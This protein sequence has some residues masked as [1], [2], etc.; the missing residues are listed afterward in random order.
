MKKM[1][2]NTLYSYNKYFTNKYFICRRFRIKANLFN[3]D[4]HFYF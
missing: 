2:I 1:N 4:I 3:K